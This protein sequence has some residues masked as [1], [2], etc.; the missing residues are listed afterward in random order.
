MQFCTYVAIKC[1]FFKKKW[2]LVNFLKCNFHYNF[3]NFI[4][5][6][7][8]SNFNRIVKTINENVMLADRSEIKVHERLPL[9]NLKLN[10]N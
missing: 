7:S 1:N 4:A 6:F 5:I 9:E 8:V 2:F 3:Y 10:V